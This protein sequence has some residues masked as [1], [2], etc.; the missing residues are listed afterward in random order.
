LYF[1][2]SSSQVMTTSILVLILGGI[3]G[4]IGSLWAVSRYL[5]V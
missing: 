1:Q 2:V 4:V 3:V 5:D